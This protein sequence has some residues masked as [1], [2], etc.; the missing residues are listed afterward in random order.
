MND[1]RPGLRRTIAALEFPDYRRF[2]GALLFS[3]LGAQILTVA[4]LWQ[5]YLI[6][7]SA[8]LLGLTG[9]ARAIPTLA[10]SLVGG[11]IADRFNR[12]RLIQIS[13]AANS[14]FALG[15][16]LLTVTGRIEL[17]HIYAFT[18]LNSTFTALTG[19]ARTALI[20][21]LVPREHLVNAVALNSTVGQVAN[22]VGPAVGG[23][24]ISGI[25][26]SGTY[27][28]NALAY[29]ASTAA[30]AMIQVVAKPAAA[31][32]TPW[33]S[34][35]E[36]LAF[37]KVNPVI[38]TLMAMD[39]SATVLG[40]YR[41]LLPIFAVNLGSGAEGLGLL[42]AAP[43]VGSLVGATVIMS[44]GNMRYKGLYTV[45]GILSYCGALVLLAVSPWFG[46]ALVA[47]A[48]LGLTDVV[49]MIPRNTIVLIITPD[50]LRGRVEAFRSMLAGGGPPLGF[51]TSGALAAVL[52][53]PLAVIAG[54]I[55]CALVVAG[56]AATRRELRDPELGTVAVES[57]A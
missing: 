4:N 23:V 57:G 13:Q 17:W 30:L 40:S 19:P 14:L 16:A 20:P 10:L 31:T 6:T 54:A 55:G 24:L 41:A 53:A 42:T 39:T 50:R 47:S 48:L 5:V 36:G 11:V 46:L 56:I 28:V 34:L 12:V 21:S 32:E 33:R 2:A 26:L 9:L 37:V 44:L 51:A 38:M 25:D 49:Q 43:G 35:V 3:G 45:F 52:G 15:L 7:G 8:L 1:A 29:G 27:L 18:F 22:I